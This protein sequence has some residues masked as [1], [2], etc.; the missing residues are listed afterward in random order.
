V[1]PS[2]NLDCPKKMVPEVAAARNPDHP[3]PPLF[4]NRWSPR[5][6]LPEPVPALELAACFEA[7]RWAPSSYNEQPWRFLFA[8]SEG[9]RK[10]FLACLA[11]FNRDW[12]SGAPILMALCT[13]EAFSHDGSPNPCCELDAGAAWMAFALEAR[14]RGYHTHGMAGIM[15]EEAILRLRVPEG[16]RVLCFIAMG[17]RGP[18]EALPEETRKREVPSPR[19]P[20]AEFAL[21]GGFPP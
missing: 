13:K 16:F 2:P 12:A 11:P 20:V 1:N 3:I 6:F 10:T 7:A 19:K 15:R 17:R 9:D 14:R 4:L 5:S 18:A 21:E 8:S